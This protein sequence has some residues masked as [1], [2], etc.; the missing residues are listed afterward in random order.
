MATPS[1]ALQASALSFAL[2]SIGHTISGKEWQSDPR[3]KS[4]ARTKAWSCAKVGW[5]Q[6]SAFL[7]MTG[8]IHYQWSHNPQ[9]L[10]DPL[11]RAIAGVVNALLWA[12]STWYFKN[13][14]MDNAWAV[15]LSAALQAYS[16]VSNAF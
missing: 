3:F 2:L 6:G 16:V 12:S 7:F 10:Q 4:L 5:Y 13:G 14:V 8:I 15:G 11:N 1:R 9:A